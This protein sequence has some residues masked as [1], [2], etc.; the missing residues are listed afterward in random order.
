METR[1][2]L[3]PKLATALTPPASWYT[4]PSMLEIEKQKVFHSTWQYAASLD[5]LRLPGNYAAVEVIG[6]P[7]FYP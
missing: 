5:L 3:D 7:L 6:M 4:D 1:F 2:T